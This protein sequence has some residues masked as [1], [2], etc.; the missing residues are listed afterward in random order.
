[1]RRARGL[2]PV[3]VV[4]KVRIGFRVCPRGRAKGLADGLEVQCK[5]KRSKHESCVLHPNKG[6][7]M[8]LFSE[9]RKLEGK[10]ILTLECRL[11]YFVMLC[12]P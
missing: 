8:V 5:Q 3:L 1:M 9:A 11:V 12:A 4:E 2:A 6:L 10:I 7:R